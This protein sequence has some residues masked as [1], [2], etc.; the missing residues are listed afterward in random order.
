MF[1]NS[2]KLP[3]MQLAIEVLHPQA[4]FTHRSKRSRDNLEIIS[5]ISNLISSDYAKI[6]A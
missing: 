5:V 3:L 6:P 2:R 1:D 4:I